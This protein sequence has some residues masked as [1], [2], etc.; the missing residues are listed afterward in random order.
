MRGRGG[1]ADYIS[2]GRIIEKK[3]QEECVKLLLIASIQRYSPLTCDSTRV[4]SFLYRV[5]EYSPKW[6]TYSAGMAGAT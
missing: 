1:E 3:Q 5:F 4:T 2:R 6:C